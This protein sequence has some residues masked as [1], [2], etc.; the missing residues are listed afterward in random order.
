M[1]GE[2]FH[3]SASGQPSCCSR[4]SSTSRCPPQAAQTVDVDALKAEAARQ[5][6]AREAEGVGDPHGEKQPPVAPAFAAALVGAQL[7]APSS[8]TP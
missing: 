3:A 8:P 1:R 4:R 7:E 6:E 2:A 5:K